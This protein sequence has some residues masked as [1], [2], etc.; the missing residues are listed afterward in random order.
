MEFA[1][2][3]QR[4]TA[5]NWRHVRDEQL[6]WASNW[7][8][9]SELNFSSSSFSRQM[10]PLEPHQ[11]VSSEQHL[12]CTATQI[13]LTW[14]ELEAADFQRLT[15][16][17]PRRV[18]VSP[19]KYADFSLLLFTLPAATV[20]GSIGIFIVNSIA[21]NGTRAELVASLSSASPSI[22]R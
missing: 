12:I 20:R 13:Q 10:E 19:I 11:V 9:I 8:L 2:G 18:Q 4:Q 5:H 3:L 14:T 15:L 6:A 21:R 16:S 1:G 7:K 17:G 22:G